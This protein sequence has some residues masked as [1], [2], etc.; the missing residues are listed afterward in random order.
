MLAYSCTPPLRCIL[1]SLHYSF[2]YLTLFLEII[3]TLN[4]TGKICLTDG[5]A[6]EGN[7]LGSHVLSVSTKDAARKGWADLWVVR[8]GRVGQLAEPPC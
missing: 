5:V 3:S 4:K 2:I 7:S 8:T 1:Y 6:D